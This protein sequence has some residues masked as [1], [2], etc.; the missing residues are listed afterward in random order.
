MSFGNKP[1]VKS[2]LASKCKLFAHK[3]FEEEPRDRIV[4]F[5]CVE[6]HSAERGPPSH[7]EVPVV[8]SL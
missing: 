2:H 3:L 1:T 8:H 4:E 7:A 6:E 5:V